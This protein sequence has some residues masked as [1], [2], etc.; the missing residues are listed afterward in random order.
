MSE[1]PTSEKPAQPPQI[2]QLGDFRLGPKLGF[3]AMG[4][5]FRA[6]QL[7]KDRDVAV[8][9]LRRALAKNP[10]FIQ[11]FKREAQLMSKLRHPNIVRCFGAGKQHGRY[12]LAMELVEGYS[13]HDWRTRLGTLSVGDSFH[14]IRTCALALGYAHY[15]SLIHRDVKPENILISN[16]GE[17]KLV[18]LGLA[19]GFAIEDVSVTQT[20]KGAGT[21]VYIAPEQARNAKDADPRSDLYALGCTLYRLLTGVLPFT[22]ENSLEIVLNKIEGDFIPA[23][24][25]NPKIPPKVDVILSTLLAPDPADRYQNAEELLEAIDR[26]QLASQKL[27]FLQEH[28]PQELEDPL[29]APGAVTLSQGTASEADTNSETSSN[30]WYVIFETSGKWITLKM[31]NEE[32]QLALA[33]ESFLL[34]AKAGVESGDYRPLEYY[35][36]LRPL[37][38][39]AQE[40]RNDDARRAK[41]LTQQIQN[42]KANAR[43]RSRRRLLSRLIPRK[44]DLIYWGVLGTSLLGLGVIG[45]WLLQLVRDTLN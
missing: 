33:E 27:E 44:G 18:D 26:L 1:Q 22:G 25:R 10:L 40:R 30:Q 15:K 17:V 23:S 2:T 20:G 6:R 36:Q 31:T 14:V 4:T 41:P 45:Y 13:L 38:R 9:V 8:K 16:S 3:G 32:I 34:T 12:F 42:I 19:K 28:D 29:V 35:P 37:V 39:E 11:R 5:I 24:V 43:S 7:S 21:P